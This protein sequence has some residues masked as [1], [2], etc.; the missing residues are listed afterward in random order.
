[1]QYGIRIV[2]RSPEFGLNG[3]RPKACNCIARCGVIKSS[4]SPVSLAFYGL[5][6]TNYHSK[7]LQ[8]HSPD[9]KII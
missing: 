4:Q 7:R 2:L 1:M 5:H 6:Q 3:R 8:L 9:T